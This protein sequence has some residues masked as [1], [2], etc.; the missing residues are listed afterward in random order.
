VSEA[1]KCDSCGKTGTEPY[2]GWW[3]LDRPGSID[4]TPIGEPHEYD[5]CS[6]ECLA[7]L[8]LDKADIFGGDRST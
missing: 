2:F 1:R 4:I 7:Q 8:T 3:H 6:W 5:V